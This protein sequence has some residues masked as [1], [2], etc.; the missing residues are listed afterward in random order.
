MFYDWRSYLS[1][2]SVATERTLDFGRHC[3]LI[4]RQ[5]GSAVDAF[6]D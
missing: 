5:F 4:G 6:I 3:E 2:Y 1:K